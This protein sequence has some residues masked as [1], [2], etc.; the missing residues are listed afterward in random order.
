MSIFDEQNKMSHDYFK[1]DVVGAAVE[2][3]FINKR[4][5]KNTMKNDEPQN[6]Y[7]LLK[8]NGDIVDVYGKPGIDEDMKAVSLGQIIGFKFTGTKEAKKPGWKDTKI[9]NVYSNKRLVNKQWL[10]E[11]KDWIEEERILK[12]STAPAPDTDIATPASVAAPAMPATA[13]DDLGPV[14]SVDEVVKSKTTEELFPVTDVKEPSQEEV[15]AEINKI[16]VDKLSATDTEDVKT[17][18][19]EKTGLAFIPGNLNAILEQLR[20]L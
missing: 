16:A 2:G 17:K 4:V 8:E 20:T 18:V 19:M 12:T 9:I 13:T 3:T 7:T 14:N 10:E 15:I 6:V 11:N 1:F 5:V